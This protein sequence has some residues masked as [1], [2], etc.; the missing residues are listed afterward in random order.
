MNDYKYLFSPLKIGSITA[1]NRVVFSAHMTNNGQR[2]VVT[3]KHIA[4]YTERANGG[5][6]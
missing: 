6:G 1:K 2:G 4:Y 3:D 5:A